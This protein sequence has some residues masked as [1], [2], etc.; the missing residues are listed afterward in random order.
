MSKPKKTC[1]DYGGL[2]RSGICTRPAGWGTDH[3]RKGRC[4]AHDEPEA[5]KVKDH[6]YRFLE[7]YEDQPKTFRRAAQE[8]G[9]GDATIW[10]WRR[11]DPEFDKACEEAKPIQANV[12]LA[13]LEDS[14]FQQCI[15]GTA[16]G[17]LIMFT[18]VNLAIQAGR[19]NDWRHLQQIVHSAAGAD[20]S[21]AIQSWAEVVAAA[22]G[23]S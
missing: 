18:M 19:S 22:N 12:R 17:S 15:K 5:E 2:T 14:S 13:M 9:V 3:K 1:G 7:A 8:A 11:D 10:R 4:K 16:P 21:E 23:S 20:I 6:K